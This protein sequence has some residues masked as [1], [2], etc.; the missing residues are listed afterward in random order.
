MNSDLYNNK[1]IIPKPILAKINSKLAIVD[2][3]VKGYKRGKNLTKNG[4]CTYQEMKRIKNFF[5]HFD[6]KTSSKDEYD[7]NGGNDMKYFVD[8]KL[9]NEREVSKKSKEVKKPSMAGLD[10]RN[11]F[12]PQ[13]S[14]NLTENNT[15]ITSNVQENAL[16]IIFDSS[17]RILLLHRSTYPDQWMPNKWSLVGGGI[18]KNEKPIDAVRREIKEEIG[19][20]IKDFLEKFILQRSSDSVEYMFVTKYTGNPSDIV[21]N[22]ENQNYGWF[23]F[24][25]TKLL[26]TVPNLHEYIRIAI[27]K[28]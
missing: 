13:T 21:L 19:L 23:S 11:D 14:F 4:Y 27:D 28:Y 10:A 6:M 26:D 8:L 22:E 15:L 5:D 17:M 7:L 16:A 24:N 20:E 9:K 18:E 1:Y 25:Q 2:S 12:K 3:G